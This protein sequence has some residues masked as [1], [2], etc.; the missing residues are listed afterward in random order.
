MILCSV[1]FDCFFCLFGEVAQEGEAK[2]RPTKRLGA[3]QTVLKGPAH[4]GETVVPSPPAGGAAG[5]PRNE[6][7]VPNVLKLVIV[8]LYTKL[9]RTLHG[10]GLGIK[11][12]ISKIPKILK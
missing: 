6:V 10:R 5:K 8:T 3:E 4:W 2:P 7:G 12:R 9:S 11:N 1:V